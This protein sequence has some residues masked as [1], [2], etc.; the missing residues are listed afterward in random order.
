MV[1]KRSRGGS[2]LKKGLEYE[3]AVSNKL[4]ELGYVVQEMTEGKTGRMTAGATKGHDIVFNKNDIK[5]CLECKDKGAFEGGG[6]VLKPSEKG[7]GII[8]SCLHKELLADYIPFA[9]K[10]PEFLKGDKTLET[11]LKQKEDFKD[12]YRVMDSKAITKYYK[13][14]GVHYIQIEGLGLYHTGLDILELGCPEFECEV[15]MRIRCKRHTSS[16][17][18]SSVQAA[19]I[20]KRKSIKKSSYDF[21]KAEAE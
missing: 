2:S 19:L 16:T 21:M 7:L 12:E 8:D 14:K 5:I 17:M 20:Y 11:W 18:P 3:I 6:K 13:N 1:E 10:V 9:G 15:K 4:K